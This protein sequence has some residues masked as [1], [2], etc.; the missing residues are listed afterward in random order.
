MG[1]L[2]DTCLHGIYEHVKRNMYS[3]NICLMGRKR[4]A[5]TRRIVPAQKGSPTAWTVPWGCDPPIAASVTLELAGHFKNT[6][7][8]PPLC[9]KPPFAPLTPL[10]PLL[11]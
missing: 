4:S 1:K 7:R 5:G 3:K 2:I 9:R 6:L 10:P 11:A 8:A